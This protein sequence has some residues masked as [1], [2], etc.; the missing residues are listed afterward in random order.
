MIDMLVTLA[1]GF[2]LFAATTYL[3]VRLAERLA[4]RPG[5]R[6]PGE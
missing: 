5:P 6:V 3:V 1:W 4:R 2:P